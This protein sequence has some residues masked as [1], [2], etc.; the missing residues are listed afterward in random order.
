M[1]SSA[2]ASGGFIAESHPGGIS[3]QRPILGVWTLQFAFAV[4][5][6][7]LQKEG[8]TKYRLLQHMPISTHEETS[9][10]IAGVV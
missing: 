1:I 9:A 8:N 5:S 4:D 10:I 2:E 6:Y 7:H 3:N